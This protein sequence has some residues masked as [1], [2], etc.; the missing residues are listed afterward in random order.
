M[1]LINVATEELE[2]FV[3]PPVY[4]I[5]SH[6]WG[7]CEITFEAM[8]SR[9]SEVHTRKEYAKIRGAID[10]AKKRDIEYLWVD[11][12]CIDKRSS[13]ELSEAINSMFQWY[14]DA[15][16]CFAFLEDLDQDA[17]VEKELGKCR[18]FTRGWTQQE[19]I[20]PR[21]LWFFDRGW[22]ARG[23]RK[24][25]CVLL[26]TITGVQPDVLVG[27]T[28]L[29][30]VLTAVKMS[31]AAFRKTTRQEDV[32]YCL[33]GIFDVNMPLLYGEGP[34][35]FIRL[36]EEII[37][38]STDTSIFVWDS[39]PGS[40][41]SP[42]CG[43][44]ASSPDA[45]RELW[46]DLESRGYATSQFSSV[47]EFTMTN[48]GLRIT[49]ELR[50]FKMADRGLHGQ[51]LSLDRINEFDTY[52]TLSVGL[53]LK[54]I[55]PGT[56]VRI[57]HI[58]PVGDSRSLEF[59][60]LT[61]PNHGLEDL[62]PQTIYIVASY[63]ASLMANGPNRARIRFLTSPHL[64]INSASPRPNW[65]HSDDTFFTV[66]KH[67]S[68]VGLASAYIFDVMHDHPR[69]MHRIGIIIEIKQ[70]SKVGLGEPFAELSL[71][72]WDSTTKLPSPDDLVSLR[73]FAVF[74]Y[75]IRA[76]L[77]PAIVFD[78]S[79]DNRRRRF[80]VSVSSSCESMDWWTQSV[81]FHVAVKNFIPSEQGEGRWSDDWTELT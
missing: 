65:D 12:C 19:L 7:D 74:C 73:D 11:T 66:T 8:S 21:E 31:W 53:W 17:I 30:D 72:T 24:T 35:A 58:H 26:G 71:F 79:I 60:A 23:T 81:S 15:W 3:T 45:F 6:T 43:V 25:L 38:R 22:S 39:T 75:P 41:T 47:P 34:K 36:Q 46:N 28:M 10:E 16:V 14:K 56:Y 44:L 40:T 64:W 9:A 77:G 13:A 67:A 48:K 51:W 70:R 59:Q 50:T 78:D 1:R 57:A 5:L 42:Y 62:L 63:S 49:E 2:E 76:G 80:R 52:N 37:K 69:T 61:F 18:W 4:A 55:G 29:R 27:I 32:A 33:L 20:A 54:K 68:F